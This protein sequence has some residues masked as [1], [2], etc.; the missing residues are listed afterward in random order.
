[1]ETETTQNELSLIGRYCPERSMSWSEPG[2]QECTEC[3]CIF[4][5]AECDAL[6]RVCHDERSNVKVRGAHE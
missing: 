1:M 5:G 6:C 2:G 3:G 4:I